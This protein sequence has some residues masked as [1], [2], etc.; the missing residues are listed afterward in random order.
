MLAVIVAQINQATTIKISNVNLSLLLKTIYPL[1]L[2]TVYHT[3]SPD[4]LSGGRIFVT[5][6]LMG[7]GGLGFGI[8]GN[9][10]R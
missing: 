3:L 1:M 7:I 4:R 6:L 9:K 2:R 8:G 5:L 10:N